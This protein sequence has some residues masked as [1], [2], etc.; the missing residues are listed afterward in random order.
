MTDVKRETA[1]SA[2]FDLFGVLARFAP[3]IF[4]IALMI[5]FAVLEPRFMSSINLFNVMRQVSITGLL[6]IGMTYGLNSGYA[7]KPARDLAPRLFTYLAGWG[8]QVFTAHDHWWWVPVVGPMIGGV[9]GGFVY[10]LLITRLHPPAQPS[11]K[12]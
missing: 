1:E 4:L 3:L 7:I 5:I 12:P 6:A 8:E 9:V 2:G 10:D 11:S